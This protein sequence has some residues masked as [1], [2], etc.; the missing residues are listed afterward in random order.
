[1]TEIFASSLELLPHPAAI[2]D[3]SDL[4]YVACNSACRA[5]ANTSDPQEHE[6]RREWQAG[7][8]GVDLFAYLGVDVDEMLA[9]TDQHDYVADVSEPNKNI[10]MVFSRMPGGLQV[11]RPELMFVS[12]HVDQRVTAARL[13]HHKAVSIT[14]VNEAVERTV[15][16]LEDSLALIR[17]AMATQHG[18]M[19]E[20]NRRA[21]EFFQRVED[22]PCAKCRERHAD[23]E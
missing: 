22:D 23:V 21:V 12:R 17:G 16:I 5:L 4:A 6:L 20:S 1:M 7:G 18:I 15:G 2:V 13:D 8:S 10:V 14:L 11:A 3:A 9:S 19:A